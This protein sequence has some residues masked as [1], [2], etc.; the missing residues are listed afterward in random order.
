MLTI[1]TRRDR[2]PFEEEN[3]L[4]FAPM[5]KDQQ[6]RRS[7][8]VWLLVLFSAVKAITGVAQTGNDVAMIV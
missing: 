2:R 4:R 3:R 7:K 5:H 8:S 6:R 1:V